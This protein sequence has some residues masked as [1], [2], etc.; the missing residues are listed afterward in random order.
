MPSFKSLGKTVGMKGR[1]LKDLK[2]KYQSNTRK[3]IRIE[4]YRWVVTADNML[5]EQQDNGIVSSS[6]F[7]KRGV[8]PARLK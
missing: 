8:L 6:A 7:E 2:N 5:L 1:E 4:T 3:L